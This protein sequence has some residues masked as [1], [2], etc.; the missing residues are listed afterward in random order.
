M[1]GI[2]FNDVEKM[3]YLTLAFLAAVTASGAAAAPVTYN[4]K[5]TK[6]DSHGWIAPEYAFQI[7]S[8]SGTAKVADRPEWIGTSFK[9]RGKKGYRISWYRTAR[10]SAGGNVR[11]RYQANLNPSDNVVKVR[12][13]FVTVSAANKPY[14]VGTCRAE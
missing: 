5:M 11:V 2:K 14:G 13:A 10:A 1:S 12:M 6:Q 9:N 3:K 8:E 4:C 7:D